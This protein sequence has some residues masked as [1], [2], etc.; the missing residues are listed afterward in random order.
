MS[1]D[2]KH[3]EA[4]GED[5]RDGTDYNSSWNCGVE[6]E[7]N[8]PEIEV[9]RERQIKNFVAILML[10][11]GVPMILAGDEVRRTQQGNNN[12]YCQDNEISWFDWKLEEK[13][14]GMLRFF[15]RMIA[16]RKK[17]PNLRRERFF[18]GEPNEH[19][20]KDIEW[21]GRQLFTPDWHN[22][23]CR[24]LAFTIWGLSH[25]NDL[26]VILNM[27]KKG[28]NFEIPSLQGKRWL[29]VIDTALPSPMDIVEP[30]KEKVVPRGVCHVKKNS[31]VVLI[32]G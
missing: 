18:T 31:V 27:E 30:G 3:N 11:Q 14:A 21:H 5:N 20:V 15:R 19:G 17:H 10:S 1:Y 32:S 9:L 28:I 22:P 29:K 16:F 6:G 26:H 25:D 7:T 2:H 24:M 13:N 12:A 23:N 8:D 4:N